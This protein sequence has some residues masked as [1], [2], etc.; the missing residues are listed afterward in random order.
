M[1]RNAVCCIV[2][3]LAVLAAPPAPMASSA[4]PVAELDWEL[5]LPDLP[6]RA[7]RSPQYETD[8]TLFVTTDRDL[9]RTT[10]DGDTWARLYPTPPLTE[11]LG[12]SALALDPAWPV[13]PTLL[14][15]RNVPG[16]P[17]QVYRCTDGGQAWTTV[18]TT[19]AGP[20][21]DL[22][23]LRAGD[24]PLVTFA[25]SD[26][27]QVWRSTDGGDTWAP[28]ATGLPEG[29][30]VFR[31]FGSPTFAADHT[32]Y[33]TGF[34]PLVRSTD[35]GDTWAAVDI[36]WV[37]IPRQ[38]VFSPQYASDTTLWVSYFWMEGHG[39]YPP[40]GV[41]R[42]TDGG[43]TWEL[44]NDG[45]PVEYPDGWIMGLG[46]SPNYPA[47]PALYAVER[48]ARPD[49]PAWE[50]YRLQVGGDGW[51]W[52]GRAP[53]EIPTGLLVAAPDLLLLPTRAGMWRLRTTC[54]EWVVNGDCESN[55]AW[56]MPTTPVPADYATAQAHGGSRSIRVG[57]V[58]GANRLAYS[59]AWQQVSLPAAALTVTLSAWLYPVSTETQP[60]LSSPR[61]P[62]AAAA[63]AAPHEIKDAQYVLILDEDLDV[64]G[65]LLETRRDSRTWELHV[66]DLS[67]Y[68]GETVWLYFG[69]TNDGQGGVTAMYVDDVSLSVCGP[70]PGPSLTRRLFLP[71]IVRNWQAGP[72]LIGGEQASALVGHPQSGAIYA[73][74]PQG[75]YRSDD[76]ARTWTL[77]TGSP[78]VTHSL[79]LAPSQPDV[80]YAGEGRDCY[81]GGPDAPMWKSLDGGRTWSELGAGLNLE[82]LAVHPTDPRR[83]YA[84]GCNGPYRSTDGGDTWTLQ[85][86]D[87][88]LVY[89]VRYIAPAPADDWQTVYLGCA[90]EGGGGGVIG[91]SNGGAGWELIT[92]LEPAPWWVSALAADP[93]SPTHVYFGEPHAFW[94]SA[95]GGTTWFTST[96]G[97][98]GVVYDPGAPPTHT[99]GLLSLAYVPSDPQR[100]LLGTVRGL[101]GSA[102]RGRTWTRLVGPAWQDERISGLLLTQEEPHRLFVTTSAGVYVHYR[103]AFP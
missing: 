98:E 88:F 45:L 103:S 64:V 42:S 3:A 32:L 30:D 24:G 9:R 95:D 7:F 10:D 18:F 4:A 21:N 26:R 59:S 27:S 70:S 46:V 37:D 93:L 91:S 41:V 40:N 73:L 25:A 11:S 31:I 38:V 33:L 50:L 60:F 76:G 5:V 1:H 85:G 84:R 36:P 100:W 49:G 16:G 53:D 99:Y 66:F 57:I 79:V 71:L 15:A 61:M 12:I 82:P 81:R 58:E 83:V 94:G 89:D 102:D 62:V 44:F 29:Y 52:Q 56:I 55:T 23:A 39:E 6:T 51:R 47:D 17:S 96:V 13:S 65:R 28:A 80:L 8:H 86:D 54:W 87:L 92:P 63:P 69:A 74:A 14:L 101:Y 75:F 43:A 34:G 2:L 77:M 35:G 48:T 97:L 72:L 78:P 19:P 20:I 22:A 90:T 68:A 67:A